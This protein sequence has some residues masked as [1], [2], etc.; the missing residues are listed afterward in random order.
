MTVADILPKKTCHGRIPPANSG[1]TIL[2]SSRDTQFR[3]HH[4]RFYEQVKKDE[5]DTSAVVT[6]TE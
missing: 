1:E 5:P 6:H 4:T 2:N 3:E